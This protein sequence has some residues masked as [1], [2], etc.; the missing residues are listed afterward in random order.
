MIL[1]DYQQDM[2]DRRR[3]SSHRRRCNQSPTGSGKSVLIKRSA[4]D[5]DSVAILAHRE[6]LVRQL[7]KLVPDAQVITAGVPWDRRSKKI[8]GMVQTLS[9]RNPNDLPSVDKVI[10]DEC[11][12]VRG[13]TYGKNVRFLA[14]RRA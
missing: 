13:A 14:R 11:H 7:A 2:D 8:V 6:C 9:R 4:D 12:H 5:A 10:T 1:R 3:T